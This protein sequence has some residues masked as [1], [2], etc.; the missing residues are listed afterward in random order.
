MIIIQSFNA[1]K[2]VRTSIRKIERNGDGRA[3]LKRRRPLLS[4]IGFF[5]SREGYYWI[6]KMMRPRPVR[7]CEPQFTAKPALIYQGDKIFAHPSLYHEI[8]AKYSGAGG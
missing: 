8:I 5:T 1:V 6:P 2:M 4:N 3:D 7:R